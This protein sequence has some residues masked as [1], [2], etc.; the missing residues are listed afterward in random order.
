MKNKHR[1]DCVSRGLRTKREALRWM[2]SNGSR[3]FRRAVEAVRAN[4]RP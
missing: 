2:Q 1:N 4:E 3:D